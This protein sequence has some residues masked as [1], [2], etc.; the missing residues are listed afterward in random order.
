MAQELREFVL[1]L[2]DLLTKLFTSNFTNGFRSLLILAKV[3]SKWRPSDVIGCSARRLIIFEK[4]I[5]VVGVFIVILKAGEVHWAILIICGYICMRI[6]FINF[7]IPEWSY[8]IA[9]NR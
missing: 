1:I 8:G 2:A 4:F 7:N 3:V 6:V 5:E 9:K